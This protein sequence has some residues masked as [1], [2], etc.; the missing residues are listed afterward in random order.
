MMSFMRSTFRIDDD[1][2]AKLKEQARRQNISLTRLV[3]RVPRDSVR[4]PRIG[5]AKRRR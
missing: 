4:A 1:L 2:L 5:T 3:I